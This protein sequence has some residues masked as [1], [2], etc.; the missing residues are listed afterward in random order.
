MP[1]ASLLVAVGAGPL[2]RGASSRSRAWKKRDG[3]APR[4][5]LTALVTGASSGIGLEFARI[6]A[7]NGHALGIPIALATQR[8]H[9]A[10]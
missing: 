7:S 6:L 10:R 9:I 1:P 8:A 4:Q 3:P 5:R 2:R